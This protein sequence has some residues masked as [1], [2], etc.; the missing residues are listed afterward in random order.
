MNGL[1][2]LFLNFFLVLV[3]NLSLIFLCKCFFD[4]KLNGLKFFLAVS[5]LAPLN[6]FGLAISDWNVFFKL[7]ILICIDTT[8]ICKVFSASFIK[9]L[10]TS[11][12]FLSFVGITDSLFTIGTS[13]FN[14]HEFLQDPY[15]YYLF[16]YYAKLIDLLVILAFRLFVKRNFQ[17]EKTTWQ[18]WSRIAILPITSLVIAI[19]I[20]RIYWQV[21]SIAKELL[22]CTIA[23]LVMNGASVG[24]LSYLNQQ[25]QLRRD[26]EFLQRSVKTQKEIITTW[27][28]AYKSQ[29]KLTHDF[30]N[31]LSVIYGLAEKEAPKSEL[32]SYVQSLLQSKETCGTLIVKTGRKVLDVLLSQKYQASQKK[33]IR[34]YMHLDDLTSFALS[35]EYLV[36]LISNLIDNAIEACE[37]IPQDSS[38][39]IVIKMQA[40]ENNS[41]LYIENTTSVPV[42]ILNNEII[43][44]NGQTMEHGYGLRTVTEILRRHNA[45]F[46]IGYRDADGMFC[47]SAQ[48]P[49]S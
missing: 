10:V 46:S 11:I 36:V 12:L 43:V 33:N 28:D 34:L 38:R 35:D 2:F 20:W 21:P 42:K 8:W 40:N 27:S 7:L 32:F 37:K 39:K 4:P 17:F 15:G 1:T 6:F 44:S 24:F 30:K 23:L 31:Q 13:F 22:M 49:R 48:I 47:F 9:S 45:I 26:Y 19:F 14:A 5:I 3:E 41:F 16:C 25:D 29:R 18:S